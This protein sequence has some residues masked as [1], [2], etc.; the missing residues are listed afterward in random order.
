MKKAI[1]TV[2]IPASGKSTWAHDFIKS[3]T[4]A[5][6]I[7]YDHIRH[8]EVCPGTNNSTYKFTK[9]REHKVQEI[10]KSMFDEAI[11][12]EHITLVYS[13][14]NLNEQ[15]RNNLI[16]QLEMNG[17]EIEIMEFEISY[18]E[19]IKRDVSREHGVGPS[20]IGTMYDK[21]MEYRQ[22]KTYVPDI[23]K[24]RAILVDIDGTVASKGDRLIYDYTKVSVDTPR[25]VVIDMVNAFA[26]A[27]GTQIIFLSGRDSVCRDDTIE[28]LK[29]YVTDDEEPMLYMR[30]IDDRRP[31][32]TIKEEIL[33]NHIADHWNIVASFDD[34]PVMIRK[35]HTL[36]I[37]NVF[38][39][40]K[41]TIEF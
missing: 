12:K 4:H 34:R 14:T 6:E 16:S 28:W 9:A 21:W 18:E 3:N 8:N 24:P 39:V 15:Y 36:K 20:V 5:V 35:W 26:N 31:D 27:T 40:A 10:A 22:V 7:N 2:G 33:W 19:A 32:A 29:T 1:I 25:S 30:D 17:F 37:P 13:N 41:Q 38:A 23:N 11:S